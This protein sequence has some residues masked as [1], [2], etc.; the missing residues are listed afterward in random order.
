MA[1]R[2]ISMADYEEPTWEEYTGEDPPPN[3]WFN[4]KCTK[5]KYLDED[6]GNPEQLMFVFEITDGDYAGWGRGLYAPFEGEQKWK[7]QKTLI[8]LQG[9]LKKDVTV[10]WENERACAAFVAKCKP[11]KLKTREYNDR[12][13]VDKVAPM[14]E[15]AG[16]AEA[17]KSAPKTAPASE[18]EEAAAEE[19]YTA[20]ELG[21]MDISELEEILTEEFEVPE[22]EMPEKPTRD[23]TGAKYKKA[24][25]EAILEE[26]EGED[27]DGENPE[28]DPEFE[29]GF[30]DGDPE[31]E[32]EPEPEPA[33]TTRRRRGA[34]A[35]PA[36]A[37][38]PA[39]ATTTRRRRG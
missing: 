33:P 38:P 28:G 17:K 39:K 15:V 19:D 32:P 30:D 18:P 10:D 3:K 6:N 2:T 37:T 21:E 16:G 1:K 23:R 24:L 9:G 7:M 4:A 22:E 31:P 14:L 36:K 29:D 27:P 20:E 11:V 5:V 25:I 26:Q 12:I 8:A 13:Y 35:A 34:A